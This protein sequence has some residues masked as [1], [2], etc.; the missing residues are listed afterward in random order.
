MYIDKKRSD[1]FYSSWVVKSKLWCVCASTKSALIA[2][3]LPGCQ[4]RT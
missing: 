3:I 4:E 1:R 2:L